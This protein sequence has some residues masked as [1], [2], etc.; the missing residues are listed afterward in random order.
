MWRRRWFSSCGGPER[1]AQHE[2]P[3]GPPPLPLPPPRLRTRQRSNSASSSLI[4]LWM[5]RICSAQKNENGREWTPAHAG[6]SVRCAPSTPSWPRRPSSSARRRCRTCLR[7]SVMAS[8]LK[9]ISLPSDAL[10]ARQSAEARARAR[11]RY[12][13]HALLDRAAG[14]LQPRVRGGGACLSSVAVRK[15]RRSRQPSPTE[16]DGA[17][18]KTVQLVRVAVH[19]HVACTPCRRLTALSSMVPIQ[20][21]DKVVHVV[22]L[23]GDVLLVRDERLGPAQRTGGRHTHSVRCGTGTWAV[24][25]AQTHTARS[26]CAC[27]GSRSCRPAPSPSAARS[28]GGSGRRAFRPGVAESVLRPTGARR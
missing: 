24:D 1:W 5:S 19:K 22:V 25:S 16:Q 21:T 20:L 23:R 4:S 13:P 2:A 8:R 27:H 10:R 9:R 12:A 14:N 18:L 26:C 15:T 7:F 3:N 17:R 6:R 28:Q 11:A